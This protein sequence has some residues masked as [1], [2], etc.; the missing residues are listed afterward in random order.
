MGAHRDMEIRP[1]GRSGIEISRIIIGCG[2]IGAVGSARETIGKGLSDEEAFAMLDT[3]ASMGISALDTANGYA[4]GHSERVIGRW[5]ADRAGTMLVATKVGVP[6]EPGQ[7][8]VDLSPGH[9]HRQI[10]ASLERLGL[11]RIDMYLSHAPD[12][13]TPIEAT[14][15]AFAALLEGGRVRAIG[16]CNLTAAQ[17]EAMLD[18]SERHQLPR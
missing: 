12:E 17:L 9:I 2:S 4:A 11:D 7:Q 10:D 18:A 6:L 1:L 8:G 3:A 15:T 14:L 16:G 5:L 13:S